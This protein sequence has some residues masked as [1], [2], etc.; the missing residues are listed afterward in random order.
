MWIALRPPYDILGRVEDMS[1]HEQHHNE[2]NTLFA[3]GFH[4]EHKRLLLIFIPIAVF[5]VGYTLID[6]FSIPGAQDIVPQATTPMLNT[7]AWYYWMA[8]S[9]LFVS[10]AIAIAYI[11]IDDVLCSFQDRS[12]KRILSYAAVIWVVNVTYILV[13]PLWSSKGYEAVGK[14]LFEFSLCRSFEAS[15]CSGRLLTEFNWAERVIN[16][17]SA[18]AVTAVIMGAITSLAEVG[19]AVEGRRKLA[20]P[21]QIARLRKYLVLA[22]IHMVLGIFVINSWHNFPTRLVY[23]EQLQRYNDI[24]NSITQLNG[25]LYSVIIVSYYLPISV[26]LNKRLRSEETKYMLN[27]VKDGGELN[28][29][30]FEKWKTSRGFNIYDWDIYKGLLAAIAP[31]IAGSLGTIAKLLNLG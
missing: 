16:V 19:V 2:M 30:E 11:F 4:L 28:W 25:V 1:H 3:K 13:T 17:C 9:L 21:L 31:L 24:S 26:I 8:S 22:A 12:A 23:G 7:S 18:F 15:I 29:Q 10:S 27:A 5:L 20:L 14:Q 6:F